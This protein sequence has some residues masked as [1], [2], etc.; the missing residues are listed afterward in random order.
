[1]GSQDMLVALRRIMRAIALHSKQLQKSAG[2]TV[3]QLMVLQ[4]IVGEARDASVSAIAKRVNLSQATVTSVLDRL[5]AK[6]LVTRQRRADDRRKVDIRLTTAGTRQLDNA[7]TLLQESFI[8]RF[9][10][11]EDWEQKMLIAS[12]ERLAALMDAQ[13]MDA[14]PL[15]DTAIISVDPGGEAD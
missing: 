7:P 12:V 6:G 5:S 3:P 15:L 9:E 14:S 8:R 13:H 1:M 4:A 11:L 10:R 2:L